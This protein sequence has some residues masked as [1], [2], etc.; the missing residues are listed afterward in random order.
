[1]WELPRDELVGRTEEGTHEPQHGDTG[2]VVQHRHAR[3]DRGAVRSRG[4]RE[5]HDGERRRRGRTRTEHQRIPQRPLGLQTEER[6]RA[7]PRR[8]QERDRAL[9]EDDGAGFLGQR[10]ELA[11]V[12][13]HADDEAEPAEA[14]LQ[15]RP[16]VRDDVVG[17]HAD[18]GQPKDDAQREK[19]DARREQYREP[20]PTLD[21]PERRVGCEDG[22]HERARQPEHDAQHRASAYSR[23]ARL[24]RPFVPSKLS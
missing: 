23:R 22:E 12:E 21:A 17:E 4:T 18:G 2:D 6:Q 19:R 10:V 7:R 24:R 16:E 15:R 13:L 1:M 8:Q 9:G 5:R 11:H 3:H 14:E 20:Q